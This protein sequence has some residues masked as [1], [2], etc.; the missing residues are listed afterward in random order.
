MIQRSSSKRWSSEED[1]ML[2]NEIKKRNLLSTRN[3]K[4]YLPVLEDK[5]N[6]L[7]IDINEK[8]GKDRSSAAL[9]ARFYDFKTKVGWP[10]ALDNM[11]EGKEQE[12]DCQ[13]IE[14]MNNNLSKV[15]EKSDNGWIMIDV[16]KF[17]SL[18]MGR[19]SYDVNEC[20]MLSRVDQ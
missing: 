8:F 2:L 10:E 3:N 15:R 16:G 14:D 18:F 12:F 6:Q 9:A 11:I 4:L 1:F 13:I 5:T 20:L 17:Q 19:N 7:A